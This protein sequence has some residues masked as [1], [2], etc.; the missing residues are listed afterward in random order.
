MTFAPLSTRLLTLV[1]AD[2]LASYKGVRDVKGLQQLAN[3][4]VTVLLSNSS[5]TGR[6]TDRFDIC[7]LDR[8][9]LKISLKYDSSKESGRVR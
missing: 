5:G 3:A 7:K 2:L 1:R 4:S 8:I 6:A 9:Q